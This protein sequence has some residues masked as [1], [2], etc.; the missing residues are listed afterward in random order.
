MTRLALDHHDPRQV[1]RSN[2]QQQTAKWIWV[3]IKMN[4]DGIFQTVSHP[5]RKY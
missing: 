2:E 5:A 3:D 1:V 4:E